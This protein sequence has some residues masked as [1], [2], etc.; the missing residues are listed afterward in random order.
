[1][2]FGI[3]Y[4]VHPL[5]NIDHVNTITTLSN[6]EQSPPCDTFLHIRDQLRDFVFDSL[7]Q[8]LAFGNERKESLTVSGDLSAIDSYREHIRERFLEEIGG[9]PESDQPLN[10]VITGIIQQDGYRIEKIIFTSRPGVYIPANLYMPDNLTGKTGAVL[11]VS[12]HVDTGK[13]YPEYQFL[14]RVLVKSGLAVLAMDSYGLGERFSYINPKTNNQDV[15]WG[16]PEH[17]Y[18]GI[19]IL[20]TGDSVVRYFVHDAMRA[21]DYLLSR[22]EIDPERIGVTGNSGGGT[23]TSLIMLFDRRIA[24]AAPGTFI[25]SLE[26][27]FHSGMPQDAEQVW[28]NML[29]EGMDHDDLLI[30][31]APKPVMVLAALYDYFPINST[32]QTYASAKRFYD[33]YNKSENLVLTTDRIDH[34]YSRN[35]A[36]AAADFFSF[37]LLGKHFDASGIKEQTLP[38][39]SLYCTG[40]G[41][42]RCEFC[43]AKFLFEENLQRLDQVLANRKQ[44]SEDTRRDNALSWLRS[45]VYRKRTHPD[46]R[47]RRFGRIIVED[48]VSECLLFEYAEGLTA[49]ALYF[50]S[51]ENQGDASSPVT[52]ALWEDG[53]A[54]LQKHRDF[55][56]ERCR[57]GESVLVL[58]LPGYGVMKPNRI[59]SMGDKLF[60][61]TT[62]T[63]NNDL[64][65]INDSLFALRVFEILGTFRMLT[66]ELNFKAD[67]F[68]L[69]GE[70]FPCVYLAAAC[71]LYEYAP[72]E[73]TFADYPKDMECLVRDRLYNSYDIVS[74]LLPGAL[75]YFD[76]S[77]LK[78][79]VNIKESNA[80]SKR[81][82]YGNQNM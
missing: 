33:L 36:I 27:I 16:C 29:L 42:I 21:I 76:Y 2:D 23:L 77:L 81:S 30:S 53:T 52:L 35:L 17:D 73:C 69:Y 38:V 48:S 67:Q 60:E 13:A 59:L 1:M 74:R 66:A 18:A 47:L 32:R 45:Q 62:Y 12:G 61:G 25:A 15:E 8:A 11:L 51:L 6:L 37:H 44:L 58:D 39:E 5:R 46:P 68:L 56:M 49:N 75:E 55:I 22:P 41:Q 40:T 63:L 4:S 14:S 20:M 78:Q 26:E 19:Q 9:L 50:H 70:G 80:F 72:A 79:W 28:K 10:P 3:E 82:L 31:M 34:C 54:Q 65:W 57:R 24:A 71:L 7:H 43:D 64:F